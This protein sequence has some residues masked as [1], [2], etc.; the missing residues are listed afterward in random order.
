M[1]RWCVAMG[2]YRPGSTA[3][4]TIVFVNG[5]DAVFTNENW[6]PVAGAIIMVL[7]F[8]NSGF[9]VDCALMG[10]SLIRLGKFVGGGIHVTW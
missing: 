2:W 7:I 6:L 4:G 1:R 9:S 5:F 8:I 3:G 10:K